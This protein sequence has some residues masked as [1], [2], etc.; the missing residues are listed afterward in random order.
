MNQLN[1]AI[2]NRHKPQDISK[3]CRLLMSEHNFQS[4]V[5][6]GLTPTKNSPIYRRTF[7]LVHKLHPLKATAS[8]QAMVEEVLNNL[9]GLGP[10]ETLLRDKEINEIMING[11]GQVWIE[12]KGKLILTEIFIGLPAIQTLIEK[13]ISPLG[14][15]IDRT[16]PQVDARLKDGSRVHIIAPPLAI[17]GPYITIRRFLKHKFNLNDFGCSNTTKEMLLEAVETR[18]NIVISG[19][20]STGKTTMLNV[21]T[22][23]IQNQRIVTIEDTA[24]LS[25]DTQ[26]LVRL[27]TR[28]ANVEGICEISQRDLVKTA[29]RMR[30]DRIVLGEAR[31]E[32]AFDMIQ[33]MNTGNNGS[34]STCH[35]N[36]T[37]DTLS[38]LETMML[39]A[40][41]GLTLGAIREQI[42]SALDIVIYLKK[43]ED[44]KRQV[45]SIKEIR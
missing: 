12:K 42:K 33:A 6:N 1:L 22:S 8:R 20:T 17:D 5:E 37:D 18:K 44:G 16:N 4:M 43:A 39:M 13:I 45:A 21:L 35:A 26:N 9:L 40:D 31:G 32:E 15:R 28:S 14:L 23:Q 29:L 10:L 41:T 30:P 36:S 24:E 7:E 25:L 2:K 34:L 3:V 27:Q 38:R 19:G 11:P